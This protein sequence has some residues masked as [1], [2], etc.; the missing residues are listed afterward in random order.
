M[1]FFRERIEKVGGMLFSS[2][3]VTLLDVILVGF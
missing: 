3:F 2:S 1:Q